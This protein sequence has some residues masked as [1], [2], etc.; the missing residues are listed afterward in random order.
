MPVAEHRTQT[1]TRSERLEARVTRETKALCEKAAQI[2]G[3]SLTDF[4]VNS[5]L[6]AAKRTV[7]EHEYAEL[8]QR[9]RIA[10]VEALLSTPPAPNAR[11]QRAVARHAQLFG[12]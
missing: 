7:R 9:D 12:E 10:F 3:S 8:T 5:S 2:Q 11:L 6:E 1:T 4:V